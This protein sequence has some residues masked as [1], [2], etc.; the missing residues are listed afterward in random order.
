MTPNLLRRLDR[1]IE[2][3][4]NTVLYVAAFAG[5]VLAWDSFLEPGNSELFSL[6]SAKKWIGFVAACFGSFAVS[7][8]GRFPLSLW[9]CGEVSL[10]AEFLY[11]GVPVVLT[12]LI[13]FL[14]A[15]AFR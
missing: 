7:D 3:K 14:L 9:R 15:Y 2:A 5:V 1:W 12:L 10:L 8:A 11:R 4:N 6:G 13:S